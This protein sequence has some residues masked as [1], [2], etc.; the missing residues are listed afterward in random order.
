ME[1][2]PVRTAWWRAASVLLAAAV[3]LWAG[4]GTPRERYKVLSFF[5]DGVPDPDAPRITAK[6]EEEVV[7]TGPGV[8]R[9]TYVS[10]HKP[11]VE[12]RCGVCHTRGGSMVN[13]D[14]AYRAC[15]TC[16]QKVTKAYRRMHGPVAT[17]HCE[18]CHG[19]HESTHPALLKD[20][21]LKV[22]TACHDQQLLGPKPVQHTDGKTSCLACHYG[23][24]GKEAYFLKAEAQA[25]WPT[26]T[27]P[28]SR[29]TT[30]PATAPA[31]GV[32]P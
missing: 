11:Y 24:G 25:E 32:A 28:A 31:T 21:A 13:F 5:F 26:L 19:G 10:R 29:P 15:Q 30:L 16:H 17:G 23:H 12:G 7:T 8:V 9:A 20:T 18:L 22:C 14:A 27:A 1:E 6:I 3:L 4:C 2:R